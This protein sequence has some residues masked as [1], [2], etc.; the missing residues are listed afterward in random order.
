MKDKDK[1]YLG[2]DKTYVYLMIPGSK[3]I[4]TNGWLL[5]VKKNDIN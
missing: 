2:T 1:L 5:N 4:A 3:H